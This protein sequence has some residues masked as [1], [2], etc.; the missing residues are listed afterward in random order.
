[1]NIMIG[2]N[3]KYVFPAKVMLTSLCEN[4]S[5]EKHDVYVLHDKR[6]LTD[7]DII[8]IKE[9]ERQYSI[10]VHPVEVNADIFESFPVGYHFSI[11]TYFRFLSQEF[12]PNTVERI[13]W[14]DVDM[15]ILKSLYE[16]YYQD[17]EGKSIVACRTNNPDASSF[18]RR[19]CVEP[20]AGYFNAGIILFNMK[21]VF[22]KITL[23]TYSSCMERLKERILWLDQDILNAVYAYDKKLI[24]NQVYNYTLFSDTHVSPQMKK[25]I[26]DNV[27]V[28]HYIGGDKPWHVFYKNAAIKY[29][30]RYARKQEDWLTS[31]KFDIAH[32]YERIC[33]RIKY[34]SK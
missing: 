13:L 11:E 24:E 27:Y 17:F 18:L 25:Y 23:Q 5:F 22:E 15:I 33:R 3:N 30:R 7:E 2:I 12:L 29:F 16:F 31:L 32:L 9:L 10:N 14:L 1:M 34:G 21:R 4:N 8:S 28:L 20:T 19:L 6:N 26:E